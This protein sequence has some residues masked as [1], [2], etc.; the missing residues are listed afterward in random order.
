MQK[1][2]MRD[3]ESNDIILILQNARKTT[4]N[5]NVDD[6]W[7]NMHLFVQVSSANQ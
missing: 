2:N 5:S 6:T 4:S 1:G 3:I 7:S